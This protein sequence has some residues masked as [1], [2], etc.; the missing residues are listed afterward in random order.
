MRMR[1]RKPTH[2]GEILKAHYLEPLLW[3][4]PAS[5]TENA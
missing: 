2:P 4:P 5:F 3:K 1:T